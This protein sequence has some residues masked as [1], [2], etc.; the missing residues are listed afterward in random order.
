MS[1]RIFI[2]TGGP[3]AGKTTLLEELARRGFP[4]IPEAARMVIQD[5]HLTPAADPLEFQREV[6]R[7]QLAFE[8]AAPSGVVFADRGVGD[9]FGYIEYYRTA[10]GIDILAAFARELSVAWDEAR[11]R[12]GAIF[13][14]DQ[15]LTYY[16][17]TAYRREN[18]A[19]A[20]AVH[21]ALAGAY[22]ARHRRVIDVPWGSVEERAERV[23]AAAVNSQPP[24]S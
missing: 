13:L 19:E 10:R 24:T 16:T 21:Q 18:E 14:L 12:Y 7:R 17:P 15:G 20:A 2:L 22:R 6:L 8:R 4:V 3:C 23:I 5:G 9:H 11:P 1:T